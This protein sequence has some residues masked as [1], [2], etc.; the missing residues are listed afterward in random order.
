MDGHEDKHFCVPAVVFINK[1]LNNVAELH[2]VQNVG[3][4]LHARQFASQVRHRF[5]ELFVNSYLP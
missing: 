5:E 4:K 1:Y 2:F 3:D